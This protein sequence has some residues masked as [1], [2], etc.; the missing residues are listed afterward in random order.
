MHTEQQTARDSRHARIPGLH[1]L[2]TRMKLTNLR[3]R[4]QPHARTCWP[5]LTHTP[6]RSTHAQAT[7]SCMSCLHDPHE[8]ATFL[9]AA[10]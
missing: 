6:A 2:L 9:Y 4:S 10:H 3:T 1:S 5:S 7:N 8:T